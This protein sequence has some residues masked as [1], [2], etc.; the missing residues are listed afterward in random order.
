M[1]ESEVA[2]ASYLWLNY[3]SLTVPIWGN[4]QCSSSLAC[5]H[6]KER[7][8]VTGSDKTLRW[9]NSKGNPN[10]SGLSVHVPPLHPASCKAT[11]SVFF[12]MLQW[13]H[14][15]LWWTLSSIIVLTVFFQ[16]TQISQFF[17]ISHVKPCLS[18]IFSTSLCFLKVYVNPS[19][20]H[21]I[22]FILYLLFFNSIR[23]RRSYKN[24]LSHS[25]FWKPTEYMENG[26]C[27]HIIQCFL[28]A[29][30][31]LANPILKQM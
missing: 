26:I 24:A 20:S 3:F 9:W 25:I 23:F 13:V 19:I 8:L 2:H 5:S 4:E 6:L 10:L 27:M 22:Q 28:N 15:L 30:Y 11:C 1:L 16:I 17:R 18:V 7:S 14:S 29:S 21:A 12:S 31:V